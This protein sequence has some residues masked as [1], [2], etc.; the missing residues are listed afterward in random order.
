MPPTCGQTKRPQELYYILALNYDFSCVEQVGDFDVM[1]SGMAES[2]VKYHSSIVMV[3]TFVLY[4]EHEETVLGW[5]FKWG[6]FL[7]KSSGGV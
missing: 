6:A 7:L 5:Q 4:L 2:S 3:L 1:L